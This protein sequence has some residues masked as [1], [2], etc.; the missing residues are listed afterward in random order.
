MNEQPKQETAG[1]KEMTWTAP[2]YAEYSKHPM[3]F[4]AFGIIAAGLVLYGI[5]SGSWTVA[6]AFLMF[7][8]LGVIAAARK[9]KA[10]EIRLTGIGIEING[11]LYPHETIRKF[12]ILYHPPHIKAV[13]F[14][15][16]AY[17]NGL[18]RM[19]LAQQD[20]RPVREFLDRYLEEELDGEEPVVDVI[21]RRLRF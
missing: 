18:V 17:F 7:G 12:W 16:T 10:V 4:L 11:L 19:E 14:E 5:V 20:P 3:W 1:P 21:A 9:P 13:Y 15:T 2:E 6:L 8:V